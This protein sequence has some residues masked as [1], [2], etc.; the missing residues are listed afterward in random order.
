[1]E[2][3]QKVFKFLEGNATA[4]H[5]QCLDAGIKVSESHFSRIRKVYTKGLGEAIQ[6]ALVKPENQ[7]KKE[8]PAQNKKGK[9]PY[10]KVDYS[11]VDDFI[12]RNPEGTYSQFMEDY[13]LA[14]VSDATFYIRRG[15]SKGADAR[16]RTGAS[17]YMTIWSC[18]V[19]QLACECGQ[20][21]KVL[22]DFIDAMNRARKTNWQ[23]IE[24]KS[25]AVI[26]VRETTKRG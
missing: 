20:A 18:P 3:K 7:G 19:D 23:M 5:K 22:S 26:E 12:A 6:A 14:V 15:S 17:L 2:I 1:M 13:P 8:K 10:N 16:P 25:P 4:T 9:R 21:R 24:L 11:I